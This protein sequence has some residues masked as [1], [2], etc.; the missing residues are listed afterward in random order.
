[1]S[2]APS[3]ILRSLGRSHRGR[4]GSSK[5]RA[6]FASISFP[7]AELS[8]RRGS[9]CAHCAVVFFSFLQRQ[10]THPGESPLLMWLLGL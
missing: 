8:L 7:E 5:E 1:M 10:K 4:D 9:T 2:M 6:A 3:D